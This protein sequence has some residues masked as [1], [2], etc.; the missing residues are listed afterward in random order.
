MP[1]SSGNT[2]IDFAK[3]KPI[4]NPAP[5]ENK[6]MVAVKNTGESSK[7]DG[8]MKNIRVLA[9]ISPRPVALSFS[10][11]STIGSCLPNEIGE[12]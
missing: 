6:H 9:N 1:V 10:A 11:N 8:D 12:R 4:D 5:I 3:N 2:C 7:F